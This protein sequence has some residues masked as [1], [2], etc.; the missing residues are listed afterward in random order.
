MVDWCVNNLSNLA[1]ANIGAGIHYL[2]EDNPRAIGLEI[3]KWY[4]TITR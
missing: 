4:E 1:T 3:A 2:Q